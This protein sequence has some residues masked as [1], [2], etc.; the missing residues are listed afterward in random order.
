MTSP[1]KKKGHT[2]HS[3]YLFTI[4]LR[5]KQ[6]RNMCS[7]YV[8]SGMSQSEQNAKEICEEDQ[9]HWFL[10]LL[11]YVLGSSSLYVYGF[12]LGF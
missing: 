12:F 5:S 8:E 9:K 4:N 7:E 10:Q 11:L 6:D 2:F 1:K 3:L